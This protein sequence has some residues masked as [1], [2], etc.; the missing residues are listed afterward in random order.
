MSQ[1]Q[2][3]EM[4]VILAKGDKFVKMQAQ[5]CSEGTWQFFR[6]L[7]LLALDHIGKFDFKMH[8]RDTVRY[9]DGM[10]VGGPDS[11]GEDSYIFEFTKTAHGKRAIR[12]ILSQE[13][14]PNELTGSPLPMLTLEVYD[15]EAMS[16]VKNIADTAITFAP[17]LCSHPKAMVID[18]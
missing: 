3:N 1:I 12:V 9:F 8:N 16:L 10:G 7:V 4:E 15:K 5:A 11:E 2:I 18:N 17:N 13:P 6:T 14:P